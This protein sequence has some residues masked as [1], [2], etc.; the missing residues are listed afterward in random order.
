[1][2][3][4]VED[5]DDL[6][7]AP[8]RHDKQA[9]AEPAGGAPATGRRGVPPADWDELSTAR[10]RRRDRNAAAEKAEETSASEEQELVATD[11][12]DL[13]PARRRRRE[14]PAADQADQAERAPATRTHAVIAAELEDDKDFEYDD[15]EN[16]RPMLS[17]AGGNIAIWALAH[18]TGVVELIGVSFLA[19]VGLLLAAYVL[20]EWHRD[21]AALVC[22]VGGLP[23]PATIFSLLT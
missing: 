21:R 19:S 23:L 22:L 14:Q 10:R 7:A 18:L 13:S 17:I 9:P 5:W 2:S 8:R 16:L 15:A 20:R 4:A 11:W 12:D 6:S 1:M 3:I